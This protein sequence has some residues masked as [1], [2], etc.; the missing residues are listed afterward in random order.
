[1]DIKSNFNE[2]DRE[3]FIKFLNMVATH[4]EFKMN[5]TEIVEYFKLLSFMQQSLLP[6][7]NANILEV[8]KVIEAKK[9]E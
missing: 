8:K 7:I 9:E 2:E 1:M 3:K 6:K 4:A 5:T